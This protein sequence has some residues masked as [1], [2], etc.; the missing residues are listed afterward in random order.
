MWHLKPQKKDIHQVLTSLTMCPITLQYKR[1]TCLMLLYVEHKNCKQFLC[2]LVCYS[3][4]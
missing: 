2:V 4:E 3:T 1:T